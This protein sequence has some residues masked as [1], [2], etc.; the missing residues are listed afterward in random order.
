MGL[1]LKKYKELRVRLHS[2]AEA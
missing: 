1:R 2:A